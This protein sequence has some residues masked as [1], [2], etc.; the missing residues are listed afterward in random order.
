MI[1]F[2]RG[3]LEC[4][5]MTSRRPCWRSKQEKRRQ[6]W[7]SEIFRSWLSSIFMQIPPFVSLCKYDL[8]SH[9]RTYSI[10]FGLLFKRSWNALVK[11]SGRRSLRTQ[12]YFRRSFLSPKSDRRKYVCVRRLCALFI[13]IPSSPWLLWYSGNLPYGHL[14]DTV[15]SL[16]RPN[17]FVPEKQPHIFLKKKVNVNTVIR[18][19]GERALFKVP[20]SSILYNFTL[21]KCHYDENHIFSI[22]AILKHK[23]VACMRRKNAVYYF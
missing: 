12:S 22:E 13:K 17:S 18:R 15:T 14:G 9:E 8:W 7:R 4:V 16:L 2:N 1:F 10:D 11:C 3:S 19:Y 6:C 5:H 20:N 21:L 23:Q